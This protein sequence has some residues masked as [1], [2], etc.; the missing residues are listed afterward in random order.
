MIEPDDPE[1]VAELEKLDDII[2]PAI[3]GD[4]ADLQILEPAWQVALATL[5]KEAVQ[6]SRHEYLRYAR[7][8][9]DYLRNQSLQHPHRILAVAKILMLLTGDDGS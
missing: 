1:V 2:Y 5:G 9:W 6:E 3:D 8:T 4:E 7:S